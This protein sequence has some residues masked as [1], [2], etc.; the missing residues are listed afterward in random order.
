MPLLLLQAGE[1]LCVC[2]LRKH[3]NGKGRGVL[4]AGCKGG[5]A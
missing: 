3:A 4:L 2:V 5:R 1:A